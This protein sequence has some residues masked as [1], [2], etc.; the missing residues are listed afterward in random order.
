MT[1]LEELLELHYTVGH[2]DRPRTLRGLADLLQMHFDVMGK[3]EDLSRIEA[4]KE[5]ADRLSD[6]PTKS[7]Q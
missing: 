4:L 3:E 2:E 6:P 1:C 7:T 5:E